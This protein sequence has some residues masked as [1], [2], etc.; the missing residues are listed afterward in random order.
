MIAEGA[1]QCPYCG[2]YADGGGRKAPGSLPRVYLLAAL[3]AILAL[4]LPALAGLFWW[5]TPG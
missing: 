1:A 2:E 4:L 3:L 5:L